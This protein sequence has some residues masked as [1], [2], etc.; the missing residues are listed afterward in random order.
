MPFFLMG[1]TR[2][3]RRKR[4]HVLIAMGVGIGFALILV[5]VQPFT[6]IVWRL[7]DMLFVSSSPSPNIIIVAIDDDTLTE[8]GKWSDWP[9]SLHAQ[10]VENLSQAGALAIGFDVLFEGESPDDPILT[11][12]MTDAGNVVVPVVGAQQVS[13]RDSE[14]T[15]Q[16]FLRPSE[17]I[18][19]ASSDIGHAN[20]ASDGDGVMR[21]LPLIVSDSGGERYPA[22]ALAVLSTFFGKPIPDDYGATDGA[23]HL[24]DRDIPVDGRK[25]MRINFVDDPGSFTRISY[26][27]V[28]EGNFDQD[29]VKH[30]II[31]V[32]MTATGEPDSWIT[33]VSPEKMYGI[34]IYANAIDTI[35]RQRFLVET[36]WPTTLLI[37]LLFVGATGVALPLIRL[38]WG[39]LLTGGLFVGY[40]VAVSFAFHSGFILNIL[41]P[42]LVLP[43]TLIAVIL[44]RTVA[45][46]SAQ[47]EITH[48]FG[49]YVSTEVAREILNLADNDQLQS[50]GV[51]RE[52]T[53]L[54]ADIRGFS[55]L[56][57]RPEP[58]RILAVLN[59]YFSVIIRCI[60]ANEGM[61]NQFAG[62]CVK[63]VWNAPR[64]QT[65]HA[66]LAV[67]AALESQTAL[68]D[69]RRD[70]TLP[71]V[72]FG[73]GINSGHAVAGNVGSEA[74]TEY[75]VI[76]DTV[77]LAY[78]LCAGAP[79]GQI[80]ISHSTYERVRGHVELKELA[81]LRI[82][83][84]QEPVRVYQVL[85]WRA[86]QAEAGENGQHVP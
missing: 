36:G 52:S 24:L 42:L 51:W 30:N 56:C 71:Q 78:A 81:P 35:L 29:V 27:D 53:V 86:Q 68:D 72:Q 85:E 33:P 32:G 57:K 79:G 18:Y 74:R 63:A 83:G 20:V 43:I 8:Y 17:T 13:P 38:R 49:R 59:S 41:Y 73:I 16:R 10:A 46:Q 60:L 80:W 39:A 37:A 14:V 84:S 61:I 7:S 76:G 62:D 82:K 69:M 26:A 1:G 12:A 50:E 70:S 9:R 75:T 4:N 23:L 22:F 21:K 77:N 19:S 40:L 11:K 28:I 65:D 64:D 2:K 58:E 45:E 5:L 44:C 3:Q 15:F 55:D 25:Q 54:F 67:K 6:S 47:R 66:L 48:L 31:L 34:E